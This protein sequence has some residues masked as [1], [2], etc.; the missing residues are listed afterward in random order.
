MG[1]RNMMCLSNETW[2]LT[3]LSFQIQNSADTIEASFQKISVTP[4]HHMVKW[5]QN[6]HLCRILN[7]DGSCIGFP[8]RAGFGGVIWKNVGYYL[9][10]NHN[11]VMCSGNYI[12]S[13]TWSKTRMVSWFSWRRSWCSASSKVNQKLHCADILLKWYDDF[14]GYRMIW[15]F[16]IKGNE[17][18]SPLQ[19]F[20]FRFFKVT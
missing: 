11:M 16:D 9:S 7:V 1:Y 12:D 6:N 19:F 2:F 18:F 15:W 8:T 13:L 17:K 5:N 14:F 3:R 20:S 4:P 10:G